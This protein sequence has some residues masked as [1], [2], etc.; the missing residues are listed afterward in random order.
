MN[1]DVGVKLLHCLQ[2]YVPGLNAEAV[3]RL[4]HEAVDDEL[5]LPLLTAIVLNSVWKERESEGV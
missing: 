4:D 2:V 5:S 3:L 1:D